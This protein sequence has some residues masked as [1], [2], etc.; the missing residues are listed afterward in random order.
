MTPTETSAPV[1]RGHR[2]GRP[3][4]VGTPDISEPSSVRPTDP[5]R[6]T[7]TTGLVPCSTPQGGST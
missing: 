7:G 4:P 1:A 2:V 5:S 3:S 6:P